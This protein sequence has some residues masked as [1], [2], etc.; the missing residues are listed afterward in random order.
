MKKI[1]TWRI[2]VATISIVFI[3]SMWLK[4]GLTITGTSISLPLLITNIVV[5]LTKIGLFVFVIFVVKWF[6]EKKNK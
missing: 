5:T 6:I 2:V 3:I 4:K 1:E